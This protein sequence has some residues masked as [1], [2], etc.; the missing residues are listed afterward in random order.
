MKFS[1]PRGTRDILPEEASRWR[2][3]EEVF[4]EQCRLYGFG[5]IRT[6]IFEETGLFA[7]SIGEET[8]IVTKQ[9]YTFSDQGG[10]SLTLRP[11]GTAGVVRAYLQSGLANQGGVQR[12]FYFGPFFRYE[13]PQ[14]GRF[15][16]FYQGG[17]EVFGAEGPQL[18]A[19]VIALAMDFLNALGLEGARLR[20]N[21]TGCKTCRPVY[22][23][24][25]R[26]ALAP[27]V[28]KLCSWCQE[29][30]KGNTL[31][32][33]DEKRPD[34]R[35]YLK[36]IP[37]ILDSLDKECREHFEDLRVLLN[38][39]G[40]PY[41][42]ESDVVRGLDYYT[43]TV[44]EINQPGLGAQD[45]LGGG[46]RYDG[47]VEEFG[48]KPTPAVGWGMGVERIL[49]ALETNRQPQ[50]GKGPAQEGLVYFATAG[51]VDMEIVPNLI[52]E[53]R[54]SG[55]A[56]ISASLDKALKAQMKEASRQCCRWVVIVGEDE[57]AAGTVTLRDMES[58]EQQNIKREKLIDTLKQLMEQKPL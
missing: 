28:D 11:E 15:R 39:L 52:S 14:K 55:M 57:I 31:R 49:D 7:R 30:Y 8:E 38:G 10:R 48:G 27:V 29:R 46:G 19:E 16:Q 42:V 26:K 53:V 5:E 21:S 22:E 13:R 40:I 50:A 54:A 35:R 12:L 17:V 56:A 45:A 4:R 44:F 47:L 43:R 36:D 2:W 32:I 25:L 33:L 9:M 3:L 6:P 41:E 1:A 18:D 58:G 34:C 23:K 37:S 24:A 51:S 20:I